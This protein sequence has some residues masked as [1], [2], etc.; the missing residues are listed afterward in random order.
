MSNNPDLL[1]IAES[2]FYT[3]TI[4]IGE[5][6]YDFILSNLS[7]VH[8]WDNTIILEW[9]KNPNLLDKKIYDR[10]Q[11]TYWPDGSMNYVK[12]DCI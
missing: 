7:I 9:R 5:Q 1:Y 6:L 12:H 4:K 3:F 2:F 11:G 10:K 8:K